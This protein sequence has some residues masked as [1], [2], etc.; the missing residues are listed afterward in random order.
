MIQSR[1]YFHWSKFPY[2]TKPS[3]VVAVALHLRI[4]NM[5]IEHSMS[6]WGLGGTFW[7]SSSLFLSLTAELFSEIAFDIISSLAVEN[8]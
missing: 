3:S 7:M 5:G 8:G 6:A 2:V 4:K 1:A